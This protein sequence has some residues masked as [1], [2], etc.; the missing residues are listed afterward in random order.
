MT[1]TQ[2]RIYATHG[3]ALVQGTASIRSVAKLEGVGFHPVRGV[4]LHARGNPP[5]DVWRV[6]VIP[7]AHFS[8]TV[9]GLD[10]AVLFG[11]FI[12]HQGLEAMRA[13]ERFTTVCIGD[14]D[15]Q[16]STSSYD[17]GKASAEGKRVRADIINANDAIRVM[18][19]NID[20]RVVEYMARPPLYLEGNHEHRLERLENDNPE[21]RGMF[22]R[23]MPEDRDRPLRYE[24]D[25][26]G[27]EAYPFLEPVFI[28]E[29]AFM[30]YL[31]NP[32]NGR[33]VS[34][35]NMARTLLLKCLHSVVVG[36][37]HQFHHDKLPRLDGRKLAA[38]EVGCAYE[39]D[40]SFR[41]HFPNDA[42]DRGMTVLY[43]LKGS[44]F[45][46]RF[47]PFDAIRRHTNEL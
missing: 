21:L 15:D 47:Y 46:A 25:M 23:G 37:G 45:D 13:G 17:K 44:D 31:P 8:P 36:H 16:E 28:D 10:R 39:H 1:P 29:V 18:N 24:W 4:Y 14:W 26:Y 34:S 20:Q 3:T 33:A 32:K 11:R 38:C 41:G 19:D 5:P 9:G 12:T 35:V 27:W 42:M 7:D 40:H 22:G 43:N 6:V 30:H 2:R